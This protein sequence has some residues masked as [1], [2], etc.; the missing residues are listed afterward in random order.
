MIDDIIDW[1]LS[2]CKSLNVDV[3]IQSDWPSSWPSQGSG[4]LGLILYNPNWEPAIERPI[5]LAHEIGHVVSN[6]PA[7]NPLNSYSV[8]EKIED[9]AN[10]IAME[11]ILQYI[12]SNDL[13]FDN[14][15]QLSD[16][17]AIPCSML[18]DLNKAIRLLK[19]SQN[20]H[21]SKLFNNSRFS[22]NQ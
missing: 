4:D 22:F 12:Q 7:R 21:S 13:S 16:T 20:K 5:T 10:I 3:M 17:F 11:L 9:G 19:A 2:K 8:N 14:R 18:N 15:Q 1:L 6:D